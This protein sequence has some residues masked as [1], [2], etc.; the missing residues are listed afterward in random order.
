MK[1]LLVALTWTVCATLG[2]AP[3]AAAQADVIRGR[4]TSSAGGNE[5]IVNASVTATSLSGGVNRST[6][7]DKDGRYTITFPGGEGDYFVTIIAIGYT[8]HRFEVKRT[9]DQDILLGDARMATSGAVL[10]TVKAVGKRERPLPNDTLPDVSGTTRAVNMGLVPTDQA[11]NLAS[12]AASLPGILFVQ[13]VNGDPSGFS[14]LGLDQAQ[15]G[16]TLNGMNS[17]ASDI[18]RDADVTATVALSPYDVS[19]G[20]FSGGRQNITISHGSNYISRKSSLLLNAPQLEWTD[21]AGRALGQQYSNVDLSGGAAGPIKYDEAFYNISYELGR[22]AGNLQTLLTTSP[23]GLQTS[24]IAADSVARLLGILGDARLPSTVGGF[25]SDR[26]NDQGRVLGSLDFTPL[27]SS[28]G[29]AFNVTFAGSWNK[30]SPAAQLT[31]ALPT[32]NF[33][34]TRWDGALQGHHTAYF[35]IGILSETGLAVSQAR[36]FS[37]PYLALPA[38]SVLVNSSFA[39]GT[40]G[41]QSIAFGGTAFNAAT[42]SRSVDLTNQLSWFS[43]NNKHRLKL[44]SEI[45]RDTYAVEQANNSLGT[46][47]FNSLSEVQSGQAASFSRNLNALETSGRELIGGLSLGDSYRRT[48]DLQIVYGAR[49]DVNQ[50]LDRPALNTD[51]ERAFGVRNDAVPNGLY[52]SPR[53]GFSWTYGTAPQIGAFA[54]AARI[55][56]AVLGGGIGVFQNGTSVALPSQ[57]MSRTGLSTGVQQLTCTGVATPIPN[58]VGYAADPASVPTSCAD[59]SS[60]TVFASSVPNVTLFDHDYRSQKSVRSNLQWQ[61]AILGGR[62]MSAVTGIYSV[63]RNQPGSVDLNLNPVTQFTLAG[64]ANRP[65]YVQATSIVPA[66]GAIASRDGRVSPL[67]NHVTELSSN[68]SSVSRQLILQLSPLAQS[69]RFTWGAYYALNSVRDRTNGFTSTAG[70][71]FDISAGRSTRDWRHEVQ[72]DVGYNLFDTIR[73]F[74]VESFFSGFPYTPVVAGDVNGDGYTTN[75]RAF[76]FDP[77]TTSARASDA[78]L[79][80]SMR[81]LLAGST[82]G[83]RDCIERQFGQ[84]AGRNSCEGPWTSAASL[85]VDFNPIKVGL[86][87]RTSVSFSL[88]N[89]IGGADLLLHGQNHSHGWGQQAVPDSRLLF[90]RGFDPST[91]SYVYEVNQRFGKVSQAVSATRNPVTLTARVQVDVG[92]TRERQDLTRT[93]DR[94]RKSAG[95][96]VT[97]AELKAVYGSAGIINPMATILRA[98]DTLKLTGRQADSIATMNRAYLIRLDSIWTPVVRGYV[99]L[100]D[101]YDQSAAYDRYRQARKA[102]VDLLITVAPSINGLLTSEQRRKLPAIVTSYLDH[103]YLVGIRAGT[104]GTASAVFPNGVGV[105]NTGGQGRARGGGGMR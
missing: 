100:T 55:P 2:L 56:R 78:A 46:F 12:M 29:Q 93:L 72:F 97:A 58:W 38:A 88:G 35:G 82:S 65:I 92:P 22:N 95:V 31:T 63:N 7:T 81:T 32:S 57:A 74:W 11:G 6:K 96:K 18:P 48:P 20:Q 80:A 99:A 41:V 52:L 68:L 26:L 76:I 71:P 13:G 23:L 1:R 36:Q 9:A 3:A 33:M 75:D 64:E 14:A 45:R 39:D 4:V 102:S 79:A 69:T 17:G 73:L 28:S 25:P 61:G 67:F 90:V 5:A 21:A 40:S 66:T 101:A 53:I 37:D 91:K 19:Q 105:P 51:A 16:L 104:A 86:P 27:S 98:S 34:S 85:R 15:N 70:N 77:S 54:G 84:L 43:M 8:P 87:Q 89:P 47:A 50:F 59:E 24:G 103:R 94:G 44:T 83:A 49:L 62:L 10:D 42:T 30:S 60:G